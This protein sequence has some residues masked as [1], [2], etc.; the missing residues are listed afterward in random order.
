MKNRFG[1]ESI[2]P[3]SALLLLGGVGIGAAL[4]YLLDP[5]KGHSRRTHLRE[6]LAIALRL[7][8]ETKIGSGEDDEQVAQQRQATLSL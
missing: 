3:N 4:V 7:P 2:G 1:K 5:E 6:R 8:G